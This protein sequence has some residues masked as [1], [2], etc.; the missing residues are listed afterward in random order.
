MDTQTFPLFSPATKTKG[1]ALMAEGIFE[2]SIGLFAIIFAFSEGEFYA[3]FPF[4][5]R[6]VAGKALLLRFPVRQ[7]NFRDYKADFEVSLRTVDSEPH[8]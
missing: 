7:S 2:I 3:A 1:K 5:C 6:S 4:S 8:L